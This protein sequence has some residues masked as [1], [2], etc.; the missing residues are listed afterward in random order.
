MEKIV[1]DTSV[2]IGR[3]ITELVKKGELKDSVIIIPEIV[4]G[5]LESQANKGRETG[6]DGLEE[7]KEL[8]RA[9]DSGAIKIEYSGKR[10]T[11]DEIRAANLGALDALIR[12]VAEKEKAKLVTGDLV[13]FLVAQAKGIKCQHIETRK[14]QR[15][16]I[17]KYFDK[18]TMSVHLKEGCTPKA[19]KGKPGDIRLVGTGEQELTGDELEE[20]ARDIMDHSRDDKCSVEIGMRDATVVQLKDIRI[21][22]T[23]PAFTREIEITAV[24]P[25][26][27]PTLESY[28][29][30]EKLKERLEKAEGTLIAGPPGAGKSSFAQSLAGFYSRKGKIV[31]TMEKPRDLIVE[32]EITQY[33]ALQGN[34]QKTADLLLLVR[35]DY[36]IY[37]E[38]RQTSD[39]KV[40]SDLRLA[41][42]GMAGVTHATKPVDAIQRLIGRVELGV[43]PQIV[44]TVIFIKDGKVNEVLELEL[45][46]KVPEGM[47]EADLARPVIE[48]RDFETG[49]EKYEIYSF[50]E[51]VMVMAVGKKKKTGG[52]LLAEQAI[53]REIGR[54][55]ERHMVEMSGE[56][57]AVIR[58]P[59][60]RIAKIIGKEGVKIKALEKKLGIRL[61]IMP[62]ETTETPVRFGIKHT[63]G[64]VEIEIG[65]GKIGK[66][67]NIYS[68]GE[69]I[70]TERIGKK[71]RISVRRNS[72]PG[73]KLLTGEID[74]RIAD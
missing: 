34:M 21:T 15:P 59:E 20:L 24:R 54:Y 17:E 70:L 36:T 2:I 3:K 27:H 66:M 26:A 65:M 47:L 61:K 35:P 18:D 7:L 50:G 41:G 8:R 25:I 71:G 6:F 64:R 29:L 56:N 16:S 12:D 55:S 42:V 68:D 67:V 48:I 45:S 11:R 62:M 32:K 53:S 13:Q 23:R 37:D 9:A 46:V 38:L 19:K 14:K 22:I 28:E 30:S 58:V 69:L 1:P 74:V 4:I 44:D 43:I 5:E 72:E 31:K 40:Y 73:K 10:P 60:E 51:E 39:F 49:K 52:R 57:S 33:G 63:K